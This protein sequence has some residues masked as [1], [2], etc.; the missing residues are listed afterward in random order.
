M[1]TGTAANLGR[2]AAGKTG[3]TEDY[4]N[5]WFVG[6]TPQLATSVWVGYRN[7]NQPLI[8]VEGVPKMAGGTIPAQIWAS[9]MKAALPPATDDTR[10]AD[11]T[12]L[13]LNN[14]PTSNQTATVGTQ[15]VTTTSP[16]GVPYVCTALPST[17]VVGPPPS[18]G[19]GTEYNQYPYLRCSGATSGGGAGPPPEQGAT[20][21]DTSAPAVATT[22][23]A[24]SPPP[25]PTSPLESPVESP[26]PTPTPS[27]P[28][29]PCLLGIV[30]G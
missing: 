18:P 29:R 23:T 20:P 24:P 4:R 16:G 2:P 22:P 17:T 3:T 8:G 5:A 15:T 21:T 27:P 25:S 6:Y 26:V 28:P 1:G 9:Y 10:T 30:C 12:D 14:A 19:G 7:A 11:A 13:G